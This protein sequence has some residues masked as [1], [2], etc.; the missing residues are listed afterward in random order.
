MRL[1][2]FERKVHPIAW[3]NTRNAG[4]GEDRQRPGLPD[5]HVGAVVN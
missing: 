5:V 1:D 2:V 4:L 3:V